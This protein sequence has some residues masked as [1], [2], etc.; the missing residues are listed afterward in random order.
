M[1]LENRPWPRLG[2]LGD[3]SSND[4]FNRAHASNLDVPQFSSTCSAL[5]PIQKSNA[6][7]GS[8]LFWLTPFC[9][10]ILAFPRFAIY[11]SLVRLL[12]RRRS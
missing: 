5:S 6:S 11:E 4:N 2:N 3:L 8:I 10:K 12:I 7:Y 9:S 1:A